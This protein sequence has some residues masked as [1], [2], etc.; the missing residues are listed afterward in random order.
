MSDGDVDE[1][2]PAPT[3]WSPW[4]V[5][6][7][8]LALILAGLWLRRPAG[9]DEPGPANEL[10]ALGIYLAGLAVTLA[11]FVNRRRGPTEAPGQPLCTH[12]LDPYRPGVHFCPR[13]SCPTTTFAATAEYESIYAQMWVLGKSS[14]QP[15]RLVHIVGLMIITVP[16]ALYLLLPFTVGVED[17]GFD[18][19]AVLAWIPFAALAYVYVLL[20]LQAW[21]NWRRV[22]AGE[23]YETSA[24]GH[25]PWWT[26]DR[27]WTL[28]DDAEDAV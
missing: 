27:W 20:M 6:F 21:R 2:A 22:Q 16:T 28:P 23:E 14:K 1:A 5:L 3:T 15:S 7:I 17:W 26:Y 11:L 4:P 25:P 19:A 10:L 8:A 13:C 9:L 18:L 12:C 24:Y